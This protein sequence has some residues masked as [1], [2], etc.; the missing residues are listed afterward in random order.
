MKIITLTVNPSID[1]STNI[2]QLVAEHKMRCDTPRFDA[3][4]GGINVSKAIK[5][6]G[7]QSRAIFTA[8]GPSGQLLQDLLTQG[9]I[10][11]QVIATQEWTRENFIV[12]ETSTNAQY[13]FGMAGPT[14]TEAET[15]A[16]LHALAHSKADYLVASGSL[17]P[18]MSPHFYE[19]VAAVAHQ[20]NAKLIL[21]TSGEP[22]RAACDEGVFL[23]KPSVDELEKLVGATLAPDDVDDAARTLIGNGKCEVVVVSLGA[24]GAILVTKDLCQHVPAP[25]IQKRSTVG[26]GD[27]MVAGMT[28]ALAQGKSF[29]EMIRWGVACGSAA[30]M[31]EGTQ[32]FNY[33]DVLK[34]M[35]WLKRFAK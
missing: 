31:N 18:H 29:E 16:I 13:R 32:L 6:L 19:K 28:W 3:G 24:K 12:T 22:L 14:L 2:G 33:Q 25:P 17:P 1:K 10:D 8:G 34:L 23:L 27:S 35:D 7:G 21:D 4:G 26:A 20:I 5:K 11:S 30:T 15:E 9:G